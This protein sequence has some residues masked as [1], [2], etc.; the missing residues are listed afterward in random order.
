MRVAT[1]VSLVVLLLIAPSVFS[2]SVEVNRQNRTIEVIVTETVRVDP[3]IAN[4]TMGCIEYGQT[5]DQAYQANLAVA[6]K[7]IK[8]LLGAGVSKDQIE[9]SSIDLS[10][11][12]RNDLSDPS[13]PC[14]RCGNSKPIKAGTCAW[15]YRMPKS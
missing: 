11:S 15:E 10:E 7:V 12:N 8:A 5:H 6:D 1:G 3:D 14:E 4:I 2:Q 9:S 13:P